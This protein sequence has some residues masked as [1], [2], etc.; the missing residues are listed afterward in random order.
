[1]SNS[2]RQSL[3]MIGFGLIVLSAVFVYFSL[4]QPK[5]YIGET[6]SESASYQT[7]ESYQKSASGSENVFESTA[8]S[9]NITS[10]KNIN[11][12]YPLN[13]NTCTLEELITI[14]GIGNSRASAIL[15][16]RDYL[17]G[18]TSVEQIKNIKGIGESLYEKVS[19]YLTV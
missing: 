12:T 4:S 1:M 19:P 11:V 5:V 8:Y 16:Y 2:K 9:D 13:L 18:Y 3:I 17:G 15:E 6:S 14:E 7:D 10:D